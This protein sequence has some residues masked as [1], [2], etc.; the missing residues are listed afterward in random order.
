MEEGSFCPMDAH[1]VSIAEQV[2]YEKMC[3]PKIVHEVVGQ[4][5]DLSDDNS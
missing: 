2:K 4:F 5:D 3:K 1:A